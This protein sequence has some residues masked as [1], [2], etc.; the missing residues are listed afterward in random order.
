MKAT[1]SYTNRHIDGG[2]R[3]APERRRTKLE[4]IEVEKKIANEQNFLSSKHGTEVF[5][6]GT[7]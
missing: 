3:V 1:G 7:R 6:L 4:E 5:G 2:L